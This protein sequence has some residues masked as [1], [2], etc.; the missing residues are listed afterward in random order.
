M[1]AAGRLEKLNDVRV[2]RMR[3]FSMNGEEVIAKV[4]ELRHDGYTVTNPA[5]FQVGMDNHGKQQ[6]GIGELMPLAKEKKL[7]LKSDDILYEYEPA[8]GL[9]NQYNQMF[10][11]GIV[12]PNRGLLTE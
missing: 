8:D 7:Q 6:M 4:T 2:F 10:G 3:T 12:M 11:S 9:K 5:V 1:P